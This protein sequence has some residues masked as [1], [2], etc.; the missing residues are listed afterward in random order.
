MKASSSPHT[1]PNKTNVHIQKNILIKTQK[2]TEAH[3]KYRKTHTTHK[4]ED[5]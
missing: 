2:Q 3:R 1:R 5:P 4:T